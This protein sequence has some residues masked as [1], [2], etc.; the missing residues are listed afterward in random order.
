M[1]QTEPIV[2][3]LTPTYNR[4][5]FLPNLIRIVDNFEYPKKD[6]E[7][8]IMDDGNIDNSSLFIDIPYATYI[9]LKQKI[10]L[11][12]KRNRLNKLAKGQYIICIDDDDYYPPDRITY[13]INALQQPLIVKKR[14]N[15]Q[16]GNVLQY[17]TVDEVVGTYEVAGT[18]ETYTYF[19][20]SE[21][22]WKFS[23]SGYGCATLAYT[24]K[25][26]I[27]NEYGNHKMKGMKGLSLSNKN[28]IDNSDEEKAFLLS[29]G[30]NIA[31]IDSLHT[32]MVISHDSNTID[33]EYYKNICMTNKT[34]KI[35]CVKTGYVLNNL[36][37]DETIRAFYKGQKKK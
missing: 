4:Q 23:Q 37:K 29:A 21:E 6:M 15:I 18:K 16:R 22:I 32:I 31:N 17:E 30:S 19:T 28:I 36:I 1:T 3:L 27:N 2:S 26:A 25:Y 9:F 14:V 5:K 13:A 33:K 34:T 11:S 12:E 20:A 8:I 7:W 24:Q 35:T 10:V